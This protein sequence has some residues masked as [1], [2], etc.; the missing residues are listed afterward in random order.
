MSTWKDVM[1]QHC[2]PNQ[3]DGVVLIGSGS[4]KPKIL[5]AGSCSHN[6]EDPQV[7]FTLDINIRL[8]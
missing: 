3:A 8:G 2:I 4:P 6:L 1:A 5:V 7:L